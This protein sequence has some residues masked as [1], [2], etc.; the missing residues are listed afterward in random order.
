METN[1]FEMGHIKKNNKVIKLKEI[2]PPSPKC[3][4]C[5]VYTISRITVLHTRV[6]DCPKCQAVYEEE[7]T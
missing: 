5:K 4:R 2:C 1:Y 6:Y 3:P 7:R